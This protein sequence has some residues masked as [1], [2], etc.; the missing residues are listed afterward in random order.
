MERRTRIEFAHG[1]RHTRL[2]RP[3]KR[4]PSPT[5]WISTT[6]PSM[7]VGSISPRSSRPSCPTDVCRGVSLTKNPAGSRPP[8]MS[9]YA[10][11]GLL[12]QIY[13]E[14][15]TQARSSLSSG[16]RVTDYYCLIALLTDIK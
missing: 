14:R 11:P 15:T 8:L 5:N 10:M 12:R 2:S 13:P 6:P 7:A 1:M 3:K 4:A 16:F 9:N